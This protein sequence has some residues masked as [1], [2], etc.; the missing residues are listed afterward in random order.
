MEI[1]RNAYVYVILAYLEINWME[2]D[3][4]TNQSWIFNMFP[5]EVGLHNRRNII[6]IGEFD[7][8]VEDSCL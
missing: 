5:R 7:E 4:L 6:H 2:N 1:S 8:R 3:D